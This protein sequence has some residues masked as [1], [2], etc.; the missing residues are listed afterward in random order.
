MKRLQFNSQGRLIGADSKW[1]NPQ[2]NE[3]KDEEGEP[4][5]NEKVFDKLQTSD[6]LDFL[7][8]TKKIDNSK[9]TAWW[10]LYEEN[11]R[12]LPIKFSN[13]KTQEDIV[14]EAVNAIKGGKKIV[15]IHGACGTGKSAIA[16]NIARK[17]GKT[18]L[19]VPVKGLQRQYEEDYTNK[20]YVIKENGQKLKIAMIT[21]RENHDSIFKP[22]ASCADPFLP[23]TIKITEKNLQMLYEYYEEN[24]L[25]QNKARGIDVKKLKR[26]SIAPTNPYWSPIIDATIN[27]PIH[28]ARKKKYQGLRGRDFI[29]YHR[30]EGCSYYDQYL[31]YLEADVIIFNSA[32]YKIE[33]ALDRKPKTEVDIIDEADEFLDSM[34]TQETLNLTK[35]QAS[36]NS[37]HPVQI[38]AEKVQETI[39]D[40]LNLEFQ[41]KKA[42]GIDEKKIFKLKDTHLYNV[43]KLFCSNTELQ[44][45]IEM[46]ELSYTYKALEIADMFSSLLNDTYVIF[47][48][49]DEDLICSLVTTN[50]SEKLKEVLEK[51]KAFVFMSGTLHEQKVLKEIFG[52]EDFAFIEAETSMQGTVEI[53][54]TGKEIDCTYSNLKSNPNKRGEYLIALETSIK[55]S[56][57]PI[58]VHVN[59]FDD[60][61]SE[62]EKII[63]NI[64]EVI[65]KEH[66]QESQMQDKTGRLISDFK[67]KLMSSLFSTR[68]SRGVDFPGD[69]C[70]SIVFTKYPN[71]N[72]QGVFWKILKET[73]PSYYWDFYR[74]K[75]RREFLQR[76]YRGLRSKND[77]VYILSPDIR[78]LNA[79]SAIQ[80]N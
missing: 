12:L 53:H 70:N 35:L 51:G 64:S 32:K 79:I 72:V 8:E 2:S 3:S 36:L 66:L 13:G 45:E 62:T 73:H 1:N 19:V 43:L 39:L 41:N 23:D 44:A 69:Q 52:I 67:N 77:F 71:P 26:I 61:P 54:R 47:S 34:S 80:K 58:L 4:Y 75:A 46:D 31:A 49:K 42:I 30:K 76:I 15:F 18:S 78:V 9:D 28:D 37:L 21:G 7:K 16:L 68:C 40:F 22:G 74:D 24:P 33:V 17:L 5:Y 50:L 11:N 59:S 63:H 48:K 55:K 60:L 6:S 38:E 56:K 20:K 25:I 57:K 29:F 10:S 65:S 27:V 14:M